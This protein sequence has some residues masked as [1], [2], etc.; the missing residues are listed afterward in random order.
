MRI[1]TTLDA[2]PIAFMS[3]TYVWSSRLGLCGAGAWWWQASL[4]HQQV[5]CSQ[6][7]VATYASSNCFCMEGATILPEPKVAKVVPKVAEM[8]RPKVAE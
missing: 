1:E 6:E 8:K 2:L 7:Y 3:L 5:S 4:G